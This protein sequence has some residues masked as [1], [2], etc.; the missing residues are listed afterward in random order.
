MWQWFSRSAAA[1]SLHSCPTLCDPI[2]ART[3][4][5]QG[6]PRAAAPVG[7]F[8]RGTTRISGSLS[9]LSLL[10]RGLAPRS[11][12][13]AR[14]ELRRGEGEA[15][16][17]GGK[18]QTSVR[19]H[20]RQPTRL[21]CPWDS[22]GKKTGVHCHF[23]LQCVKVKSISR[24]RLLATPWTAAYQAPPSVGFSS[25]SRDSRAR[26]RS[27]SQCAWCPGCLLECTG[28]L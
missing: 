5:S 23:L 9:P 3:G 8:S 26:T 19:P 17:L 16:A 20:R 15:L 7:V 21:P 18:S 28:F 11:K 4:A 2:D 1:K 24:V 14:A 22:P 27:P 6:F 13:K 10:Q 12:G 25:P